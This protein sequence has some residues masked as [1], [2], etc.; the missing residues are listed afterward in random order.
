[1]TGRVFVIVLDSFGIGAAPDAADFGDAGA[2]TIK[3]VA[4]TGILSLP[5]MTSLGLGNI[6]GVDAIGKVENPKA[7][8]ARLE[9]RS[10]G[11][12]TTT[13]HWE[14]AGL[15]SESPMPTFP[16][17]FPRELL[18]AFEAKVGRGTLCNLPYSGTDVIRDYGKE[19]VETGKL[20]VYTSADS[21][22]QVAA[23]EEIVPVDELYAIC[24]TAREMLTGE[25]G[26]GRVIA[27]P[28]IGTAPDFK[29]T[30][31][32]RDFSLLPPKDTMLNK[33]S[34]A[35]LDV[36]G[37][38]KIGDIFAMSGLTETHPTH[39]NGEGMAKAYELLDRDFHGLCFVNLVD[40]DMKY[41]HRQDAVG[42]AEAL[43]A[44]DS[45]LGRA[46]PKLRPDD[47]LIIT[48]DHGCDPTDESTDHTREYVPF[49]MYGENIP[50][51]NLG[52]ISGFDYISNTVC[53]LLGIN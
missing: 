9:E 40:F 41:G 32:R 49:L 52:T 6:D 20:I 1:M 50:E 10:R 35:G 28:F 18:N 47:V 36:I 48:A 5:N 30:E 25:Y 51:E 34:A 31:N 3:G 44:F 2:N 19:H 14:M 26:V 37:V 42:Y 29:R 21:V 43:N 11:K 16:N 7:T 53:R 45:W 8:Y 4:G 15:I 27:R 24:R 22:F 12:D 13:G 23:H 38:G 33:L 46:M 39:N 17:G